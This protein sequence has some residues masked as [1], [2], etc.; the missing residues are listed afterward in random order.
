MA[1]V[2]AIWQMQAASSDL[3]SVG[4]AADTGGERRVS[5]ASRNQH[6]GRVVGMIGFLGFLG[7][8]DFPRPGTYVF[9]AF[10]FFLGHFL[11]GQRD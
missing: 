9:F 1:V 6:L 11:E 4:Q 5:E 7:F 3:Y 8:A 2:G 10:L